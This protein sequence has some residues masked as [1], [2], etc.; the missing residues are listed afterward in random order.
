MSPKVP[1]SL[2]A[3]PR[4]F[5]G[6]MMEEI[7]TATLELVIQNDRRWGT[8]ISIL[9]TTFEWNNTVVKIKLGKEEA[10]KMWC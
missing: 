1:C 4:W 7:R 9:N 6:L 5:D 3:T 2:P 8:P 10:I